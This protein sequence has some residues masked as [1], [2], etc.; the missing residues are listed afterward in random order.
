MKDYENELTQEELDRIVEESLK[1]SRDKRFGVT[2][3]I[4]DRV[5]R[6]K[7]RA[8]AIGLAASFIAGGLTVGGIDKIIDNAEENSYS[9]KYAIE[10]QKE[11]IN[12]N[13]HRTY[14]NKGYWYDYEAIAEYISKHDSQDVLIY[15]CYVNI[16]SIHTGRV[17]KYLGYESFTDYMAKKNFKDEDEYA[18]TMR[19]VIGDGEKLD[20]RQ[21]EL[22]QM[23]EEHSLTY[24]YDTNTI[25]KGGK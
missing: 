23:L 13:T 12:E 21:N 3:T 19:Q 5:Y 20:S 2:I 10:F 24:D 4:N 18:E 15:L 1:K 22:E 11:V 17:L 9:G 16:D 25:F 14:D 7:K 6:L 8:V